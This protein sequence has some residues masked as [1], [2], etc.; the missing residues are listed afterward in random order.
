MKN[1]FTF[2]DLFSGIGGFRLALESL[3]GKC[4]FSSDIDKKSCD[5]YELNFGERPSGDISKISSDEIPSH[6]ILCGGFP[7]QPFS[8]GGLRKGLALL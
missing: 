5:T 3:G 7:C 2:I 4:V 6:D 8:I 1:N